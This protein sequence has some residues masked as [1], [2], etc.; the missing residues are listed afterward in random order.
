V[1]LKLGIS[2]AN[3]YSYAMESKEFGLRHAAGALL[4]GQAALEDFE[5]EASKHEVRQSK[6]AI[7]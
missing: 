5:Q 1:T 2:M 3:F 7:E 4:R 6:E